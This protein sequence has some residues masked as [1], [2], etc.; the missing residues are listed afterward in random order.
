MDRV[1]RSLLIASTFLAISAALLMARSHTQG[2]SPEVQVAAGQQVEQNHVIRQVAG[3][4]PS[5]RQTRPGLLQVLAGAASK[6]SENHQHQ[7][8][9]KTPSTGL[10]NTLFSRSPAGNH[11]TS[12]HATQGQ[13][14]HT[15]Q[16]MLQPRAP[17]PAGRECSTGLERGPLPRSSPIQP[18]LQSRST[19][20][21]RAS[22]LGCRATQ[23]SR[24]PRRS[25]SH[26]PSHSGLV[27][28]PKRAHRRS[29]V[30]PAERTH[31]SSGRRDPAP[32][33]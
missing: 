2:Q 8:M 3:Q 27:P 31:A 13:R 19:P 12:N 28:T 1:N 21:S 16:N 26:D 23:Y 15:P 33:S 7:N 29:E 32:Q 17:T 30:Q 10:L 9:S 4:Q 14:P 24:H 11:S 25:E 22:Q 18:G 6:G 5:D 20:R